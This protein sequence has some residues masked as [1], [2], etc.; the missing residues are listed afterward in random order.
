MTQPSSDNRIYDLH[1][2]PK[3][4]G[5]ALIVALCLLG[6]LWLMLSTT[7]R[8]TTFTAE[9]SPLSFAYPASWNS[10]ES[11]QDVTLR[12]VDPGT[13]SPF[14]TSL[15][16]EQREL[17]P[18]APPTL[19]TL[20]DRR[21][22]E[23]QQLDGY[24]FL[25]ESESV[26]GGARAMVSE[27]AYVVQPIDEPRRASLPVVVQAREYIVVAGDTSYYFT[28]AAPENVFVAARQQL[29]RIIE[30]VVVE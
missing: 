16:V 14:K 18:G 22:E 8:T 23:R 30:S 17:D 7:G 10:A 13:P 11:L 15:S 26:V 21:V 19:Q 3:D 24:H 9:G 28:L 27:Y 1:M 25:D 2:R 5:V 29:D 6:G 4:L 20:L 12:V